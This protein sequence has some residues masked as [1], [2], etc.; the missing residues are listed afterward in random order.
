M[1]LLFWQKYAGTRKT[2]L[3]LFVDNSMQILLRYISLRI[4]KDVCHAY[5]IVTRFKKI[6]KKLAHDE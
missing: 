6:K 1:E 3:L 2:S 5:H 4:W